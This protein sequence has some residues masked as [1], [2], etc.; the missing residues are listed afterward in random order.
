M[1]VIAFVGPAGTGKSDRALVVA[2]ENRCSC[3]IDD[4]ILIYHNRIVAG[5][6]A[7]KEANRI[8]AVRRAIFDDPDQARDVERLLKNISPSRVLILG[9]SV[10]MVK[11]ITGALRLPEPKRYIHIEDV[12][13]P[14]EIQMAHDARHKEGKH[15]IPV[16]TMELRPEFK[17]YLIDPLRTLFRRGR[18]AERMEKS[19]VRPVFSYY[20]KLTFARRVIA[21]L[22]YYALRDMRE[23]IRV[24]SVS[25]RKT[26]GGTNGIILE[27][28]VTVRGGNPE[29]VRDIVHRA[30]R[31]VQKEIEYTT[32]MFVEKIRVSVTTGVKAEPAEARR[33]Q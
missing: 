1:E 4:G 16:P 28:A 20:G 3:I 19:V 26:D 8:A 5:R 7:K 21:D 11:L 9:T 10:K 23:D 31:L 17:G 12:A 22:V 30:R 33:S 25:S 27:M 24:R 6:S 13:R 2:Y 29:R 18:T 15:V 14:E 32:G